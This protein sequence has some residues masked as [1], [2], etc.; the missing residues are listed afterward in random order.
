MVVPEGRLEGRCEYSVLCMKDG[1]I[2]CVIGVRLLNLIVI[3]PA[4]IQHVRHPSDYL[5]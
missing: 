2:Q 3:S 1:L 4:K 5:S